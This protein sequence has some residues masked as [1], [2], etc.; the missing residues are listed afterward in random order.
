[1]SSPP[2]MENLRGAIESCE[3][4]MRWAN[5]SAFM[6]SLPEEARNIFRSG[7]IQ[8]FEVAYDECRKSIQKWLRESDI[9][10]RGNLFRDAGSA[11]LIDDVEKWMVFRV[12]RNQTSHF[13]NVGFAQQTFALISDFLPLAWQ[14]LRS[15]EERSE[16]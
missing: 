3:G 1:M 10:L 16:Y 4:A 5:D 7:V 12:A 6:E 13:Y 8:C 11:D 2:E 14:L 9:P 15:L